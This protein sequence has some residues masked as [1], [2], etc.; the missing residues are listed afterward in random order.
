MPGVRNRVAVRVI[1]IKEAVLDI[2]FAATRRSLPSSGAAWRY[3]PAQVYPARVSPFDNAQGRLKIAVQYRNRLIFPRA[4]L[5]QDAQHINTR[6]KN[7]RDAYR[8]PGHLIKNEAVF[9][10][11]ATATHKTN[12]RA[13][14]LPLAGFPIAAARAQA[15]RHNGSSALHPIVQGCIAEY[16]Q[17]RVP[18]VWTVRRDV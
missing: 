2:K 10:L 15:T 18:R 9:N 14:C 16:P 7:A 11:I 3:R 13:A 5:H 12:H 6:M 1:R 4:R 17:D 8:L